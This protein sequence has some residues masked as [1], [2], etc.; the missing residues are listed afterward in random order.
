MWMGGHSDRHYKV[1]I[2]IFA[3]FVVNSPEIEQHLD[4][5]LLYPRL[6]A[7]IS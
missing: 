3:L 5:S 1:N 7:G 2:F 4:K 6:K